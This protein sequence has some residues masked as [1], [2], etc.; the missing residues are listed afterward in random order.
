M[1]IE[2]DGRSVARRRSELPVLRIM[3]L[4]CCCLLS[5]GLTANGQRK[6]D[7]DHIVLTVSWADSRTTPVKFA[8]KDLEKLERKDYLTAI[9]PS[10]GVS[11][12]HDWQGIPVS[13]VLEAAKAQHY[14]RLRVTALDGYEVYIPVS[15]LTSFNPILAYRKDS[16]YI[17]IL[18]KG[19]LFLIYPFDSSP[20][21]QTM[22]YINRTI[23][24]VSAIVL[25]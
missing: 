3:F 1:S 14:S 11:G 13:A 9:P 8:L 6:L 21:L 25:K 23:W 2:R 12:R 24:Q 16:Q 19:P 22:E 10:L 18:D 20:K 4:T 15:D 7:Q 5:G 17:G